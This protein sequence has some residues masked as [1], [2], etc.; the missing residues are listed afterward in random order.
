M[1]A[2]GNGMVKYDRETQV[3]NLYGATGVLVKQMTIE[4]AAWLR[5]YLQEAINDLLGIK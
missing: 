2:I 1:I 5:D 4:Q 3:I